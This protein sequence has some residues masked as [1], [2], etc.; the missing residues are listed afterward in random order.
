MSGWLWCSG[1]EGYLEQRERGTHQI[2]RL[3]DCCPGYDDL[4]RTAVR[5][6]SQMK[7][8]HFIS[9]SQH[10]STTLFV[11]SSRGTS[12]TQTNHTLIQFHQVQDEQMEKSH[13]E[14]LP[15]E[16]NCREGWLS[17]MGGSCCLGFNLAPV[18]Y[19][20]L[21]LWPGDEHPHNES[22]FDMTST[23]ACLGHKSLGEP[24]DG[25]T[26]TTNEYFVHLFGLR[27]CGCGGL[28]TKTPLA[29]CLRWVWYQVPPTAHVACC[30]L[31]QRYRTHE[32][33]QA[34]LS[35]SRTRSNSTYLSLRLPGTFYH[36][37]HRQLKQPYHL[38]D[39]HQ[40]NHLPLCQIL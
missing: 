9:L 16:S 15:T 12:T 38:T 1:V 39:D 11:R 14:E 13:L 21:H 30:L 18:R 27:S 29:A 40:I 34:M 23:S 28:S 8:T 7:F 17:V 33:P 37:P 35:T 10:Q 36:L 32:R 20:S 3:S 25:R 6:Q 5:Q 24:A 2:W 26:Q 22:N 4:L 19:L 31:T